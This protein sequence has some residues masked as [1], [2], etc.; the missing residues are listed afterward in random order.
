MQKR[1]KT[2]LRSR[3]IFCGLVLPILL[4][5]GLMFRYGWL[6]VIAQEDIM[7]RFQGQVEENY[8]LQTPRGAIIDRH[9]RQLA[10]SIMARSLYGDPLMLNKPA[11]EVAAFLAPLIGV[12][13]EILTEK[14]SAHNRF[15]WLQRGINPPDAAELRKKIREAGIQGLD[16][17]EESKRFYPSG[18]LAAGLLGFVGT[19]DQGLYGL[20]MYYDEE[21]KGNGQRRRLLTDNLGRPISDS[22]VQSNPVGNRQML[23]TTIDSNIQFICEKWIDWAVAETGARGA[24]IIVMDP[25]TG[26]ILALANRP[27][28][29]PNEFWKYPELSWRN[30]ATNT[31]YEPGSTFKALVAGA[32]LQEKKVSVDEVFNDTG[33]L[34]IGDRTMKNWDGG[35]G[36]GLVTFTEIV[37]DSLNV[38][39]IEIGQRMGGRK[40]NE[41]ARRFGMGSATGVDLPGEEDGILFQD[42]RMLPIDVATMSIGQGIA[43]T[44]MQIV[45]AFSI[46]ANGGRRVQPHVVN[47]IYGPD[48]SLVWQFNPGIEEMVLQPGVNRQLVELLEQVVADGGGARAKVEGYRFAG[49]TGTAEKL[50]EAGG[51]YLDDRYIASFAGFG[52]LEDPK[53][54]VLVIIDDPV[55]DF[56]GGQIAAPIFS[57]VAAEIMQYLGI[58]PTQ[59]YSRGIELEEEVVQRT[60]GPFIQ[61]MNGQMVM[62]DL[63]GY[64]LRQT[65]NALAPHGLYLIPS[66]SGR[67][68]RQEPAAGQVIKKGDEIRVYLTSQ[69]P[70]PPTPLPS[71]DSNTE[72]VTTSENSTEN[73]ED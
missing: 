27:T 9:D 55:G 6:Q 52:P 34:V 32:A 50:N 10:T 13:Q 7:N 71:G 53:I 42:G 29:D 26:A 21:L 72:V 70:M 33:T 37:K 3:L 54:T 66:G 69:A 23:R 67:V 17:L 4:F 46:I 28:F 24:A 2:L 62:P 57:H 63:R 12:R 14:L 56:Y 41:Y 35:A 20:E 59:S 60:E 31:I 49:K 65:A 48:G 44:P 68:I 5:A 36:A 51:G 1:Q 16:F 8:E 18:K 58:P 38:G 25:K 73:E 22:A 45:S 30:R 47:E 61:F 15:V 43:V 64:S 11:E 40:L 39:F 19:D